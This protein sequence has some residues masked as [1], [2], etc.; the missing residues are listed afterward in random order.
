MGA[1]VYQG[2][3]RAMLKRLALGLLVAWAAAGFLHEVNAALAS[4]DQR[5]R[6]ARRQ[7]WRFGSPEPA[8]IARC[9]RGARREVPPGSPV[10]FAS[11]DVPPGAAF[12]RWRWAAYLLPDRDVL[13]LGDPAAGYAIACGMRLGDPRFEPVRPLPGGWLYRVRRP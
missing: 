9:V 4:Y 10:A 12:Q 2:K 6:P 11:P 5:Q 1:R 7:A 3:I 13:P 8:R